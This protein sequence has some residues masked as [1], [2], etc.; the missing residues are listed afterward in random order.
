MLLNFYLHPYFK[1]FT[2]IAI[3]IVFALLAAKIVSRLI[4]KA[5]NRA[6]E[7]LNIDQTK[8]AFLRHLATAV[9]YFIAIIFI[10]YSIPSL[11]TFSYS[12]FASAG[13]LAAFIGLASQQAFSNIVS[14]IFIVMSKPFKVGDRIEL[15]RNLQMGTVEDITLRHT[16][17][18]DFQNRRIVIPNSVIG[19]D[20]IL[21]SNL[22]DEKIRR[23]IDFSVDYSSDVDQ[24]TEVIRE[25]CLN[26]PLCIDNRTAEQ[27]KNNEAIVDVRLIEFGASELKFRAFVWTSSPADAFILNTDLNKIIKKRFDKEGITIP[28]PQRVISYRNEEEKKR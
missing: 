16:V 19:S 23:N 6:A 3:I 2:V 12:L 9:I 21:N 13:I 17:I 8:Y 22:Y 7:K 10:V 14:G 28:F 11:R 24:V 27:L 18:R 26:H 1:Q 15:V 5:M 20:V 25:E 4:K